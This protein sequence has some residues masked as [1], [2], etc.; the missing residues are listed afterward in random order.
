[1]QYLSIDINNR[2]KH[3]IQL[4]TGGAICVPTPFIIERQPQ[5]Y[6]L[7]FSVSLHA[8]L[9]SDAG[10]E[11]DTYPDWRSIKAS[12]S[13]N[14][15]KIIVKTVKQPLSQ[16]KEE[17]FPTIEGLQILIKNDQV[18]FILEPVY[19]C[20]FI[21]VTLKT[22]ADSKPPL[23]GTFLLNLAEKSQIYD[24]VM[25]FGSEASQVVVHNRANE[26]HIITRLKLIDILKEYYYTDLKDHKLHQETPEDP[27]LYRSAFFIK[28]DGSVFDRHSKPGENGE[29]ELVNLLTRRAD[30]DR[31]SVT[32]FLVSNLKLAHLGAYNFNISFESRSTNDFNARNIDFIDTISYL[33]Q[34]VI[35]YILQAT[36]QHLQ[37]SNPEQHRIYLA[38]RLLVP[39]VFDQIKVSKLVRR[40]LYGLEEIKNRYSGLL[41]AGVEV[42]TTSESDASFLGFKSQK[43][44][45]A[46][47]A[48]TTFFMTGK[49]Y[50]II[51]VGK[52][53]SD[54]SI[55]EINKADLGLISRYRSGFIGAGNIISYAYVDT[56]FAAIFGEDTHT[57]RQAIYNI[58]LS[59]VA[60][61]ADKLRFMELIEAI[62][63]NYDYKTANQ[64]YKSLGRLIPQEL[65]D[66]RNEYARQ[67]KAAGL[68]EQLCKLL[69]IVI[70]RQQ[71]MK[72]EFQ[73][74]HDSV[75]RMV[76]R[77]A[78]E[79]FKSGHY[80]DDWIDK[81]I[82]TGRGFR[83]EMLVEE[84][85]KKFSKTTI[86]TPNLK[87]ICL[88]GAF[89]RDKIN[90]DSNLVGI[91]EAYQILSKT[92]PGSSIEEK[93][94]EIDLGAG[95][96][97]INIPVFNRVKDI[98][99]KFEVIKNTWD[100][101]NRKVSEGLSGYDDFGAQ[102]FNNDG[103]VSETNVTLEKKLF[104]E[105]ISFHQF[106]AN[107]KTISISGVDYKKHEINAPHVNICFTGDEFLIRDAGS[108]SS[109]DVYPSFFN[110]DPY[111]F[112]TLFPFLDVSDLKNI[113]VR[114]LKD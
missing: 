84:I 47:I 95:F 9:L 90:Y 41:L 6:I 12:L 61:L 52:G 111:V 77:I 55:I 64:R 62:K 103:H 10:F 20:D 27:A 71:S 96:P 51:D 42:T 110:E 79:V 11:A 28:K 102:S 38:V 39:N 91:P 76:N 108:S 114:K 8:R 97:P 23:H 14:E 72:D 4:V 15:L 99:R 44:K 73:I 33:Q 80:T 32:H 37:S 7:L 25:D 21:H 68:L 24:L 54:F 31:L 109:I 86:T 59:P 93:I 22:E 70:A 100:A 69:E 113:E 106:N 48:K 105:G 34:A 81:I 45:E 49:R 2:K 89:T 43:D 16:L 57:R 46:Q 67:P 98:G 78:G 88:S 26:H 53:T 18:W 66:I 40:T 1:M 56:L 60:G 75:T 92:K 19:N 36:L 74:V 30:I 5:A 35:N 107:A 63:C 101:F 112:Q 3:V 83:F 87:T 29:K 94:R 85:Q 50:L 17:N 58:C 13:N 104:S 65:E 82:L